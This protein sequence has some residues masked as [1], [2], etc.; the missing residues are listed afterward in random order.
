[1]SPVTHASSAVIVTS[2]I[3]FMLCSHS[4]LTVHTCSIFL[5]LYRTR[6]WCCKHTTCIWLVVYLRTVPWHRDHDTDTSPR[7]YKDLRLGFSHATR[8]IRQQFVT[9]STGLTASSTSSPLILTLWNVL[10]HVIFGHPRLRLPPAWVH[11]IATLV[12]WWSGKLCIKNVVSELR[13]STVLRKTR[14]D[15]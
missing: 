11:V 10:R 7:C 15:R 14:E 12:S 2:Q 13:H 3:P 4:T 1:V 8:H 9:I 5:S 6:Q